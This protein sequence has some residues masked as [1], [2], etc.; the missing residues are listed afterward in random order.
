MADLGRCC[1]CSTNVEFS[2]FNPLRVARVTA[3][4]VQQVSNFP[5]L[6]LPTAGGHEP[7]QEFLPEGAPQA[8]VDLLVRSD[9]NLASPAS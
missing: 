3:F 2:E 4:F 5:N 7:V 8:V 9:S 1:F 6:P